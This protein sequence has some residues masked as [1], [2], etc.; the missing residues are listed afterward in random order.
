LTRRE[1]EI[2]ALLAQRWTNSE[3]A[4]LLC[5]G[6]STA[7]SHLTI[8][9]AR[10]G[11]ANRRDARGIATRHGLIESQ[12]CGRHRESNLASPQKFRINNGC[13][14]QRFA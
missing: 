10:M 8:V 4:D 14:F 11:A 12:I 3:I 13:L 1:Q 5:I 2:L 7:A 9:L 6:S